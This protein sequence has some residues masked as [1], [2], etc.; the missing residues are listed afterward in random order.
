[1]FRDGWQALSSAF[2]QPETL[3]VGSS[4]VELIKAKAVAEAIQEASELKAAAEAD[5]AKL[6]AVAQAEADGMRLKAVAEADGVKLKAAAEADGLKLAAAAASEAAKM[7]RLKR[8]SLYALIGAAAGGVLWLAL[9]WFVHDCEAYILWNMKR[10][11]QQCELP[12]SVT[13]VPR[14]TLAVPGESLSFG[15]KPVLLIAPAGAGKTTMLAEM[16]RNFVEPKPRKVEKATTQADE[17]RE[18]VKP[19]GAT[20]AG[21]ATALA[22]K[23]RAEYTP[24]P[25]PVVFIC[26]REAPQGASTRSVVAD[27][28]DPAARMALMAAQFFMQTGYPSRRSVV[29]LLL[30]TSPI[31]HLLPETSRLVH[32][33]GLL[34]V[35]SEQVYHERLASNIPEGEAKCKLLFD[36]VQDLMKDKRLKAAGGEF[37][38]E[39]LATCLVKY[40]INTPSVHAALTGSSAFLAEQ[41]DSGG[42][43]KLSRQHRYHLAD[44]SE[45]EVLKALTNKGYSPVQAQRVVDTCG[46]RMRRLKSV[47][48]NDM[49][50]PGKEAALDGFLAEAL[51]KAEH[52]INAL[53]SGVSATIGPDEARKLQAHLDAVLAGEAV[54][55]TNLPASVKE[56]DSFTAALFVD[57]FFRLRFQSRLHELAW[58]STS[59]QRAMLQLK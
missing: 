3:P 50:S 46:T 35:A 45:E 38:F 13:S 43:L 29:G 54:S 16:A 9:D 33:M 5:G 42:M 44:P 4:A 22:D 8:H 30:R 26:F 32:A 1:M 6:K 51:A 53:F 23:A 2:R 17:A 31:P 11:L 25:I 52:D 10:R 39:Q 41:F 48:E 57:K 34:F 49:F 21:E 40:C 12:R 15:K 55:S 36:E 20:G 14:P 7:T 28:N 18:G 58:A 27:S 37:V 47:F 59:K 56:L 24:A 19:T